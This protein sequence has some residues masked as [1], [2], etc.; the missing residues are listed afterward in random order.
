VNQEEKSTPEHEFRPAENTDGKKKQ[1]EPDG[2]NETPTQDGYPGSGAWWEKSRTLR[3]ESPEL[4]WQKPMQGNG[5]RR[6]R[7]RHKNKV[8][9]IA[10]RTNRKSLFE[11]QSDE[12]PGESRWEMEILAAPTRSRKQE[13]ESK[14]KNAPNVRV[15]TMG[16]DLTI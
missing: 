9:A 8:P 7:L 3:W 6:E 16:P 1:T 10:T 15:Q 14:M 4:K 13:Q 5:K 11:Q 12:P 2:E